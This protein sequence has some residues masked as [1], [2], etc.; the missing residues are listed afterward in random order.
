MII[1]HNKKLKV[2]KPKT[3]TLRHTCLINKNN[4]WKGKS[5]NILTANISKSFTG[6]SRSGSLILYTKSSRKYTLLYRKIDFFYLNFGINYKI[7]RIEY[8]PNRSSFI[9]LSIY[10]NGVIC[11]VIQSDGTKVGDIIYSSYR[12]NNNYRTGNSF[13]L[14][15]IPEGSMINNI[16]RIPFFGSQYCRSAGTYSIMIRK[17]Y[18]LNKCLIKLKSGF[19]KLILMYS[20]ATLGS[21]SN[22]WHSFSSYGKAGRSRWLG[23]KPNVRGVAMNPI[24]H[25]HGG[26]EGKKSKK[27]APRTAWGKIYKWKKTSNYSKMFYPNLVNY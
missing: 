12:P 26:G 1:N 13:L 16:E 17:Y 11:Y 14:K 22:R 9:S 4:L 7:N 8:D 18:N 23:I 3:S 15:Y 6:R 21:V 2:Y 10:F 27:P 20:K 24:D 25:P 5:L 19:Y